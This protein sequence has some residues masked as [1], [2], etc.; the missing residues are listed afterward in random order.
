MPSQGP[1][2]PATAASIN[3]G[4]T[5]IAWSTPNNIF[6]S[7]DVRAIAAN[8]TSVTPSERL[9]ATNFGFTIPGDATITSFDLTR[10]RR[11]ANVVFNGIIEDTLKLIIGGVVGGD[12]AADPTQWETTDTTYTATG[13]FGLTP[14][15]AEV[16]ASNFGVAV[17]ATGNGV[18]SSADA[19]VDNITVTVTYTV[20]V[21]DPAVFPHSSQYYP[22]VHRRQARMIAF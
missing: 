11:A 15:P 3:Q 17:I 2:N 4:G 5:P 10:E 9:E 13:L 7:N 12:N 16:N 20:P 6:T 19:E 22:Q 18:G 8:V 14:T 1:S 21:F